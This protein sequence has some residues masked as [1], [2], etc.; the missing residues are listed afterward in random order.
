MFFSYWT[1]STML[2]GEER[3]RGGLQTIELVRIY[4]RLS[5]DASERAHSHLAV[6]WY[7]R[8]PR[9]FVGMFDKLDVAAFLADLRKTCRL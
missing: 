5:Y 4:P 9:A 7:D 8:R 2:F 1:A 3:S 6:T